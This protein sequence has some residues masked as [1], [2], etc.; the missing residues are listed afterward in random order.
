MNTQL[1]TVYRFQIPA[2]S[3][4][5]FAPF[6]RRWASMNLLCSMQWK[7]WF[8]SK[9][10]WF[11]KCHW[12]AWKSHHKTYQCR[13]NQAKCQWQ[14]YHSSHANPRTDWL[15][16]ASRTTTSQWSRSSSNSTRHH[17]T[18]TPR[19]LSQLSNTW[20]TCTPWLKTWTRCLPRQP[21]KSQLSSRKRW[22]KARIDTKR[23]CQWMNWSLLSEQQ[24]SNEL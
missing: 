19:Q 8:W 5:T 23:A 22:A 24:I 18:P 7:L 15:C 6:S 20:A 13:M 14:D 16:F 12:M 1:T 3:I 9:M 10:S 4:S 21:R 2:T 11:Q 17:S